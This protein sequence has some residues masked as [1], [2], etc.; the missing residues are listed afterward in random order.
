MFLVLLDTF[1]YLGK[2][3][4]LQDRHSACV[5]LCIYSPLNSET[6]WQILTKLCMNV[7]QLEATTKFI[8]FNILQVVIPSLTKQELMSSELLYRRLI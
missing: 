6:G 2:K 7:M 3:L 8:I 4:D 5:C 1:L